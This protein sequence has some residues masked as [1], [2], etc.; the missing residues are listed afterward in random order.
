MATSWVLCPLLIIENFLQRLCGATLLIFANKQDLP[1]ALSG[2][3]IR[4]VSNTYSWD[5]LTV[6]VWI[7]IFKMLMDFMPIYDLKEGRK[8]GRK[9]YQKYVAILRTFPK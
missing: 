4:D 5:Y 3:E 2:E 9:D 8:E 6:G 1:G 7:L